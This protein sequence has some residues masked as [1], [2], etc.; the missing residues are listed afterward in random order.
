MSHGVEFSSAILTFFDD[1]PLPFSYLTLPYLDDQPRSRHPYL[2]F[3]VNEVIA[4]LTARYFNKAG[5]PHTQ[6]SQKWNISWGQQFD[7]PEYARCRSWQKIN[8]FAG[9]FLI[10]RKDEFHRRMSELASRTSS[11]VEFYPE[12]YLLPSDSIQAATAWPSHRYWIIKEF[13]N[14][15]GEGIRIVDS[16]AVPL[17][18]SDRVIQVYIE[19]PFLVNNRKFDVRLYVLVSSIA[20]LRVYL[21]EFG[22]VKFATHEYGNDIGDLCSHLT[23]VSVNRDSDAFSVEQQKQSLES[24]YQILGDR[25]IDRSIIKRQFERIVAVTIVGASSTIRRYHQNLVKHRHTAFELYG[26]DILIDETL[27]CWVLEVNVSPSMSGKDSELDRV[28]K[29]EI[30]AEMYNIGRVIDCDPALENPCPFIERYDERWRQSVV[31]CRGRTEPWNW[32]TPIFADMVMVRDFLEEKRA[33]RRFR[34]V[35]PRRK[36]IDEYVNYFGAMGYCDRSFLTW[37]QMDDQQ[38]LVAL[39]RGRKIYETELQALSTL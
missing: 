9:A 8:H 34:R 27:H 4:E 19:R 29:S 24:L 5:L 22:L 20:P 12:S 14:S 6:D 32:D 26:F 2:I 30:T 37:I 15:K 36:T 21:H 18:D 10:G 39:N 25:G 23:N 7:P 13:A 38:R 3:Y 1:I 17:P 16:A 31:E 28:Q 35:F 11:P 33:T